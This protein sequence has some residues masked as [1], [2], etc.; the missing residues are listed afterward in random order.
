MRTRPPFL[1]AVVGVLLACSPVY[2]VN[3][4]ESVYW[5][6]YSNAISQTGSEI[7]VSFIA[8]AT[9]L[10]IT[11]GI[12]YSIQERDPNGNDVLF[13]VA[14]QW[15]PPLPPVGTELRLNAWYGL[16]CNGD[17]LVADHVSQWFVTWCDPSIGTQVRYGNPGFTRSTGASAAESFEFVVVDDAGVEAPGGT[18]E[19]AYHCSA[20]AVAKAEPAP[21]SPYE[22]LRHGQ[23]LASESGQLSRSDPSIQAEPA[24]T[25]QIAFDPLG[26]HRCGVIPVGTISTMYVVARRAGPTLCGVT[27]AEFRVAGIPSDW[28]ATLAIPPGCIIMDNPLGAV[29]GNI[30]FSSCQS[31]AS[32]PVVFATIAV[33]AT[34]AV[35]DCVVEVLARNPPGNP[36][37][38]CP[39]VT[40][41]DAPMYT[42]VCMAGS[43]GRINPSP[44]TF[45]DDVVVGVEPRTWTAVKGLYR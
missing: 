9:A 43:Q 2:A 34:S 26:E 24:G 37:F 32:G 7:Y 11:S 6:A 16:E 10:D 1:L 45:C 3:Q 31:P 28:F 38:N 41:C 42:I 27:G 4:I 39:L 17:A 12:S 14:L 36:M 13:D 21:L 29:G 19:D 8:H 40:L 5:G 18:A 30:A 23:P 33:Y 35:S 25:L 44:G 20:F 22:L 15:A